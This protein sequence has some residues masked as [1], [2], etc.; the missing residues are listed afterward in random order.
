MALQLARHCTGRDRMAV[1]ER[2]VPRRTAVL[3]PRWRSAA[4]TVRLV[5]LPYNDLDGVRAVVDEIVAALIV[6][7]MMGP[8]AASRPSPDSSPG[9]ATS[10]IAPARC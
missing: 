2:R 3:R 8:P 9:S 5:R 10:A 6:E 7:P 4:G 1:F